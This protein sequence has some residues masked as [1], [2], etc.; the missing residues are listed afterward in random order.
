[1]CRSLAKI[2]DPSI[3]GIYVNQS[4]FFIVTSG[5][6]MGFDVVILVWSLPLIWGL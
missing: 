6:N 1:M 2:W 5:I 3:T 4:L